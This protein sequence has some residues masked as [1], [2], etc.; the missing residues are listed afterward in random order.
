MGR[1]LLFSAEAGAAG[2]GCTRGAAVRDSPRAA[3]GNTLPLVTTKS[4]KPHGP[5]KLST[6]AAG[7]LLHPTSLPSPHG[8]GDLGPA[9][10]EFVE[11][12]AD[13]G[14]TW[15]QVLPTH[16]PGEADSPYS[17]ISAF[18]GH[19]LLISLDALVADGLLKRADVKSPRTPSAAR[20]DAAR[21]ERLKT[22]LL[23]RAFL[24]F[25]AQ[26]GLGDAEYRR[27]S[28]EQASWLEPFVFFAA[29]RT[30]MK[31]KP[32]TAWPEDLRRCSPDALRQTGPDVRDEVEFARFVQFIF[33]RQWSALRAAAHAR[34]VSLMGDAPIFVSLNSADVWSNQPLFDLDRDGRP[35]T[36]SGCPPDEYSKT[37]QLWGHPHY[38]WDRHEESG[39]S[40][41]L[42]RLGRLSEQFDAVRID[43]FLGFNRVWV[44][45]GGARTARDGVWAR[46][47]G[48][49]L[50]AAVQRALPDAQIVAEDLGL[51]VAEAAALRDAFDLPGM[52]LI[53]FA[54]GG[55]D[56][57]SRYHQ[58]HNYPRRCVA[59]PGTHDNDTLAG[60]I[61]KLRAARAPKGGA[62]RAVDRLLRYVGGDGRA[63]H[64]DVIRALYASPA[65]TVIVPM[66][67][68]LGLDSRARMNTPATVKGNWTWRLPPRAASAALAARLRA[69]SEAFE[70]MPARG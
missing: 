27:F 69:M 67:D 4:L 33:A 6:R 36:V 59:Y 11:F 19:P 64:W 1:R 70:R 28:E 13:A 39:F 17:T 32:W 24:A 23:K 18:A 38:R 22:P 2:R 44:V 68:V 40:W 42:R 25:L 7:V 8:I 26:G 34:G 37:G 12:L 45:K 60:W 35:R 53:Q 62:L 29:L 65:D 56:A 61:A 49:A 51:L 66:Q 43:H 15:W 16:P 14:Q 21:A 5:A 57:G 3:R 54:F 30:A 47:P 52:R 58:P 31:G 41:W 50:L 46:V 10:H 9:A 20:M 63:L 48:R 55:D